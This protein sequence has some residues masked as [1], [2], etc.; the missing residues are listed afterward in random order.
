VVSSVASAEVDVVTL[1]VPAKMSG[2][3]VLPEAKMGQP[4]TELA[5][6]ATRDATL[7]RR[8]ACSCGLEVRSVLVTCELESPAVPGLLSAAMYVKETRT[9]GSGQ[10]SGT[11]AF[12]WSSRRARSTCS[13]RMPPPP[14]PPELTPSADSD[15][16]IILGLLKLV[17]SDVVS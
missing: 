14:P 12:S 4:F 17:S 7:A 15:R 5:D 11:D 10:A 9:T 6:R 1:Q 3:V 16:P 13:P 2:V 8:S